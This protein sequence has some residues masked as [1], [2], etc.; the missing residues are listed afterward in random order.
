MN[1]SNFQQLP[2][3]IHLSITE[4]VQFDFFFNLQYYEKGKRHVRDRKNIKLFK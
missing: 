3:K 2:E 1:N 4:M